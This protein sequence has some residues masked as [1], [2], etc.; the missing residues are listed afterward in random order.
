MPPFWVPMAVQLLHLSHTGR[1]SPGERARR[2]ARTYL[3]E[4]KVGV[5]SPRM[6]QYGKYTTAN[7]E[8]VQKKLTRER[9]Y[10]GKL[11]GR[12]P[13]PPPRPTPHTRQ[14]GRN[15]VPKATVH[16]RTYLG[17]VKGRFLTPTFTHY[18]EYTTSNHDRARVPVP[19]RLQ[20]GA[21]LV[22]RPHLDLHRPQA[23]H[24]RHPTITPYF[25]IPAP[26]IEALKL[27]VDAKEAKPGPP[28]VRPSASTLFESGQT[29]MPES[30]ASG[31]RRPSVTNGTGVASPVAPRR[32]SQPQLPPVREQQQQEEEGQ[33][34]GEAEGAKAGASDGEGEAEAAAGGEAAAATCEPQ[35]ARASR[36]EAVSDN[37]L[38]GWWFRVVGDWEIYVPHPLPPVLY[39]AAN[40]LFAALLAPFL[41][42]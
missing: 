29:D 30:P 11:K 21:L 20:D 41:L 17:D 19:T 33:G 32:A 8:S 26:F 1:P 10:L 28:A 38:D 42:W 4:V 18:G 6:A 27:R 39:L 34:G 2:E 24:H 16:E 9:T 35:A 14:T 37:P 15:T 12:L 3:G 23:T 13:P 40:G 7:H 36:W 25:A 22:Q 5:L 31:S